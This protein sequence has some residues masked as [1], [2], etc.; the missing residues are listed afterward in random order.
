MSILE[1]SYFSPDR[2]YQGLVYF[3]LL[4]DELRSLSVQVVIHELLFPLS[5]LFQLLGLH[6]NPLELLILR[7][8]FIL[9]VPFPVMRHF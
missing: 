4:L 3:L 8:T 2:R 7:Q 5:Q 9:H 1:D 6:Q